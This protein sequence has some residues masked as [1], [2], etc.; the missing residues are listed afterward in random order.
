[1]KI[2]I[3]LVLLLA[4]F[5]CG[6]KI[7]IVTPSNGGVTTVSGDYTCDPG[8]ACEIS[9]RNPSFD[10]TF[11]AVPNQG[12]KFVR[13][14]K[15]DNG[16]YGG[17]KNPEAW[18]ITKYYSLFP[19]LMELLS[20]DSVY[21]LEPVFGPE[22]AVGSTISGRSPSSPAT[23]EL[24]RGHEIQPNSFY[25]YFKYW[26]QKGE[27]LVL[28][29]DLTLPLSDTDKARCGSR[30]GSGP[31]EGY[32]KTQIQ[33]YDASL[34][35]I[36]GACG[37][38]LI[39]K[40]P[41]SGKYIIQFDYPENG[42]GVGYAA[43]I[44]DDKPKTAPYGPIGSPSNPKSLLSAERNMLQESSF[45]NFYRYT[46]YSGDKLIIRTSLDVPLTTK[47]KTR[48]AST[49]AYPSPLSPQIHIYDLGMNWIGGVCGDELTFNFA[50]TGTY[51]IN[52][53]FGARNSGYFD[54]A[55]IR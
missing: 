23:L 43:S 21:Y 31:L 9:V 7:K 51:L 29:A 13:W 30:P 46:A 35:R 52:F 14:N 12:K 8:R 53:A 25:N 48:C 34:N 16:L 50:E 15:V 19:V 4:V 18:M 26:A 33:I 47:Q 38:T 2:R 54:A 32:W 5:L 55:V 6:C 45:F 27:V 37:E 1:M 49:G 3:G 28:R 22:F 40:F 44:I 11:V 10:Q 20:S 36:D 17:S 41:R 24:G 39:Y 42:S